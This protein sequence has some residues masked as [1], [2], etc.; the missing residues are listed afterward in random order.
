[1][2]QTFHLKLQTSFAEFIPIV[3]SNK[4]LW[5]A[6]LLVNGYLHNHIYRSYLLVVITHV[7]CVNNELS[8]LSLVLA[9]RLGARGGIL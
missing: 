5:E 9:S 7:H 2:I 8:N 1:M 3:G 4:L 6:E